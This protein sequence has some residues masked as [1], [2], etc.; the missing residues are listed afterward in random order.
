MILTILLLAVNIIEGKMIVDF[1]N[2]YDLKAWNVVDDV[3]MGG[4]SDGNLYINK[5]GHGE[6]T[7]DVSLENNGGFSSIRLRMD[8]SAVFDHSKFV[9][10]VKGDGKKYQLRVK[11]IRMNWYSY[12]YTFQTSGEWETIEIPMNE[13]YPTFRGR[14]L[15]FPNYPG[16]TLSELGFLISNKKNES[17]K[18]EIDYISVK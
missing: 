16:K 8:K 15:D 2:N 11:S 5:D 6:F 3:V 4:R 12:A 13:M 7:G 1:S 9:L 10:R 17:F 18:L 14:K